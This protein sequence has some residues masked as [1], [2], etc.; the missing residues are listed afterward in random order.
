MESKHSLKKN[1]DY[2]S[3]FDV[4]GESD[5]KNSVIIDKKRLEKL[6]DVTNDSVIVYKYDYKDLDILYYSEKAYEIV[7]STYE[8]YGN[9]FSLK[10]IYEPDRRIF[11]QKLNESIENGLGFNED[12]RIYHVNGSLVW[13]NVRSICEVQKDKSVLVFCVMKEVSG[14]STI[15]AG[16][17]NEMQ[18]IA[19]ISDY[20]TKELLYV[21]DKFKERFLNSQ[22]FIPGQKCY[23][24]LNIDE[25]FYDYKKERL[26]NNAFIVIG[27]ITF[28]N[29]IY[30]VKRKFDYLYG[31]KVSITCMTD[32]TQT[33]VLKSRLENAVD[34]MTC[35][36]A[37]CRADIYYTIVDAN[38]NFYKMIGYSQK[39]F[40]EIHK[41]RMTEIVI[42][43]QA[44]VDK[45]LKDNSNN[46]YYFELEYSIVHKN[47]NIIYVVAQCV[48]AE[49]DGEKYYYITFF[50][51]TERKISET[52]KE[53][54]YQEE[55]EYKNNINDSTYIY[56][57]INVTQNRV[58]EWKSK[59]KVF[60]ENYI[61][62]VGCS[63]EEAIN[64]IGAICDIET[65][66]YLENEFNVSKFYKKYKTGER[67][68]ETE[69]FF[70]YN[71]E[72]NVWFLIQISL[73]ENPKT[74]DIEA[75]LYFKNISDD[76]LISLV[77]DKEIT[78][79][80]DF[81]A[82][83]DSVRNCSVMK[84][85]ASKKNKS[86]IYCSDYNGEVKR[87][88]YTLMLPED[89]KKAIEK[90]SLP[91]VLKE[92]EHN[93]IYKF[94]ARDMKSPGDCKYKEYKFT[95]L[96]DKKQF[97]HFTQRDV[98]PAVEKKHIDSISEMISLSNNKELSQRINQYM[99]KL[100]K[101]ENDILKCANYNNLTGL[102]DVNSFYAEA[103]KFIDEF[104]EEKFSILVADINNF[105]VFNELFGR[106]KGDEL[107]RYVGNGIKEIISED[108]GICGYI[109]A[110]DF[111]TCYKE[112]SKDRIVSIINKLDEVIKSFY[113]DYRFIPTVGIYNVKNINMP[114]TAMCDR[115]ELA[116]QEAKKR[117]LQY[118]E[119][120]DELRINIIKTQEI[121]N[122]FAGALREHQF[123]MYLQPQYDISNGNIVG[124]EALVR[125]EHPSKGMIPPM[126]FI[127]VLEKNGLISQLDRY[128]FKEAARV[129]ALLKDAFS[130]VLP[131]SIAVNLS[132][133][134]I[135]SAN[136]I[137]TMNSTMDMYK[138]PHSAIRLEITET[139]YVEQAK[140][141][142]EFVTRLKNSG[143]SVEMDD[144]GSG[145][146]SLNALKNI[147]FD[148][149]KLDMEFL[150]DINFN[151]GAKIIESVVFMAN[152]IGISVLSE[153]VETKEQ[154]EFLKSIGCRYVQG[155]YYSKP[156]PVEE[157]I[158]LLMSSK[159]GRF[160]KI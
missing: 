140:Y 114:I 2:K 98:T 39:E 122:E 127:P 48:E 9:K 6:I 123:K 113:I 150:R 112:S 138:L 52:I 109:G 103:R 31:R 146:S 149:L 129:T 56:A 111:I 142:S 68:Y 10:F 144:F 107:L 49:E 105:K 55:I 23:E 133:S 66:R 93:K 104:S 74:N 95:Y 51:I 131:P 1:V 153:G 71:N 12:L 106:A 120:D 29:V 67:N 14:Y 21:N 4:I 91:R 143:Y 118:Y 99:T 87:F 3:F 37:K 5:G 73:R 134:E 132:R 38:E 65:K 145:Y 62:I 8:E 35:G 47:K 19:Y 77:V 92:L 85:S 33:K 41:N 89:Q 86:I 121:V 79:E 28:N 60:M 13:V 124:A 156:I 57:V 83:I 136:L 130:G 45:G 15:Y 44:G 26:T 24:V 148:L 96:D 32:I 126:E 152:M 18:E 46:G 108:E 78:D 53:E 20:N 30:E 158:T 155:Y 160:K 159:F 116:L 141:M 119:Y 102:L 75:F 125:W 34:M 63:V 110:D 70:N 88:A 147:E 157:Y 17:L 40:E 7:G 58:I 137:P 43:R 76:K 16:L 84:A 90:L 101:V 80:Y 117:G 72:S 22:E 139:L 61:E 151:K 97:I 64:K 50:D 81:I 42:G 25:Q 11:Q 94:V 128:I 154:V 36:C 59:R 82:C 115:A 100:D 54:R 135:F 27:E 69:H